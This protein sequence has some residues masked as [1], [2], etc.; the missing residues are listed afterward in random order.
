MKMVYSHMNCQ[1]A[2][3]HGLNCRT[4]QIQ[5]CG[6]IKFSLYKLIE[7]HRDFKKC[8]RELAKIGEYKRGN[9]CLRYSFMHCSS[10]DTAV[11]AKALA[12]H[13]AH[14]LGRNFE[15]MLSGLQ[16]DG[17]PIPVIKQINNMVAN[18]MPSLIKNAEYAR[19]ETKNQWRIVSKLLGTGKCELDILIADSIN[20]LESVLDMIVESNPTTP[21]GCLQCYEEEKVKP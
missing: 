20:L 4:K 21:R 8:H 9:D 13:S 10:S 1:D 16:G 3:K 5:E 2:Y 11:Y 6:P 7:C 12:V 19:I 17:V 15:G 14:D 18:A